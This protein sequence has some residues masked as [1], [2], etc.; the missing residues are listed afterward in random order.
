LAADAV[1][2]AKLAD[3]AVDTENI[4]D[5]A[6]TA[7]LIDDGAVGT[8]A[9]AAGAVTTTEL[10]A[11]AVTN[12]KLA[13]NAVNTENITDGTVANGDLANDG[14]TIGNIDA[15]L[16]GT[17]TTFTG[18]ASVTSTAFAGNLTGNVNGNLTGQVLTAS[19]T[20]ITGIPSL[21]TVGTITSGTWQG[22]AVADTYVAD[23]LTISGGTV[24]NTPIGATT[25]AAADVTALIV[26]DTAIINESRDENGDVFTIYDD[27]IGSVMTV[28]TTTGVHISDLT[29]NNSFSLT[30][31]M[32]ASSYTTT[33]GDPVTDNQLARKAYVDAQI[34]A[35][36]TTAHVYSTAAT[37]STIDSQDGSG[38]YI[39]YLNGANV[40]YEKQD[41]GDVNNGDKGY[42]FTVYGSGLT[43]TTASLWL[44]GY[45][46]DLSAVSTQWNVTSDSQAT[47]GLT[48]D[49][50]VAIS[51]A[52][53]STQTA[54][55]M[56]LELV[57]DDK[58][59]GVQF[60]FH[61][62]NSST[63]PNANSFN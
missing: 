48:Y 21:A 34:A 30:G 62:D 28:S 15:S 51:T 43:G 2:N 5:D 36:M 39:Y 33:A 57:I 24:N 17:Y 27:G 19:Q 8:A 7:A 38:Q 42:T 32:S 40:F 46:K 60:H 44:R 54:G 29:L 10:G 31:T 50:V 45:E 58:H 11:D 37:S 22:T 18:L 56:V 1:T 6:I 3:D 55:G 16:G 41:A 52:Q 53:G 59:S 12:A 61:L 25:A 35:N 20:S 23:N 47:F 14:I 26:E 4:A 13:D 63:A 49:E 9:I